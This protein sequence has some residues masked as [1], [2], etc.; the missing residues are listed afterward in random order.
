MLP[1]LE[2]EGAPGIGAV[3]SWLREK[4]WGGST[5]FNA[6]IYT[7]LKVLK[8]KYPMGTSRRQVLMVFTD[9]QFD[10]AQDNLTNF[11]EM[12]RQFSEARLM[13][14]TVVFWN[15]RGNSHPCNILPVESCTEDVVCL[16]GY[17]ADLMQDFFD[18]M[19]DGDFHVSD[20]DADAGE[21]FIEAS[22]KQKLSTDAMLEHMENSHMYRM[23]V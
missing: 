3:A 18:M 20:K 22:K 10:V 15:I 23:Y 8:K 21:P 13:L 14:P 5:D 9:M 11:Q 2:G 12:R 4:P 1:S 16:S 19:S 6:S 7:M 17:S